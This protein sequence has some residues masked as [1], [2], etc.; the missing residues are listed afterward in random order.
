MDILG[1]P[2]KRGEA[3]FK[4]NCIQCHGVKGNG[5][6]PAAHLYNP[7]PANLTTSDKN[8]MYKEMIITLGGEAMGRSKVMPSWKKE[9]SSQEIQDVVQYINSLL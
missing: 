3:V 9:L 4:H 5:K 1:N 8:D 6:G 2:I 7:P